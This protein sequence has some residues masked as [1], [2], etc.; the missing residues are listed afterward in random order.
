MSPTNGPNVVVGFACAAGDRGIEP[1]EQVL[2]QAVQLLLARPLDPRVLDR[3]GLGDVI[4]RRARRGV[5]APDD[6]AEDGCPQSCEPSTNCEPIAHP[7]AACPLPLRCQARRRRSARRRRPCCRATA[8]RVCTILIGST[9][10]ATLYAAS[11]PAR[12]FPARRMSWPE[13]LRMVLAR[14]VRPNCDAA[15]GLHRGQRRDPLARL[16]RGLLDLGLDV[17]LGVVA[18][19][20]LAGQHLAGE[21]VGVAL[22]HRWRGLPATASRS[23][24]PARSPAPSSASRE[25]A[26]PARPMRAASA[27]LPQRPRRALELRSLPALVVNPAVVGGLLLVGHVLLRRI[28]GV[29]HADREGQTNHADRITHRAIRCCK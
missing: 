13:A 20:L 8:R 12:S 21:R 22:R 16:D 17:A 26:P 7:Y 11:S 5:D 28:V 15:V 2:G 1:A 29:G 10:L 6:V 23:A 25:P 19:A 3:L 24:A 27:F 9:A 14:L 18:G 4:Q